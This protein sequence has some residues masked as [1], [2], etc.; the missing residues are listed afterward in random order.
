MSNSIEEKCKGKSISTIMKYIKNKAIDLNDDNIKYLLHY[1]ISSKENPKSVEELIKFLIS[2]KTIL[3]SILFYDFLFILCEQ[4]KINLV[5]IFLDNNIMINCQ[6][7][8]GETP[9]HIAVEKNNFSLVKLLMNYSPDLTLYT[10]N[11]F[12]T[13]YNYAENCKNNKIKSFILGDF[14]SNN[15]DTINSFSKSSSIFLVMN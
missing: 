13:V 7:E 2:K 9:M 14:N 1:S 8:E 12:L 6:N 3:N 4:G 10:Y 5:K 11:D 15:I